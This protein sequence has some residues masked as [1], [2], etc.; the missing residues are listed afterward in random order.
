MARAG[1][2]VALIDDGRTPPETGETLPSA[3]KPI[4]EYLGVREQFGRLG[5]LQSSGTV[6]R[7]GVERVE[8]VGLESP[9][10]HG[11]IVPKG[12]FAKMLR[13]QA[14]RVGATLIHD[15]VA[16]V[17]VGGLF[18]VS[19]A[20]RNVEARVLVDAT[21]RG[22]F[23]ARQL[24]ARHDISDKLLAVVSHMRTASLASGWSGIESTDAGWCYAASLPGGGLALT[25]YT[26]KAHLHIAD[27][28]NE[29]LAG[30]LALTGATV[31]LE[32][33][34]SDR[35]TL[36]GLG[37]DRRTLVAASSTTR[38]T[39]G[40]HWAAV[41]DAACAFDPLASTG[42]LMAL[43]TGVRAASALSADLTG[44]PYPLVEYDAMVSQTVAAYCRRRSQIY[45][46]AAAHHRTDF[47]QRR[48]RI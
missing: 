4:L 37:S 30:I 42:L 31:S 21:G 23:V 9:Y 3:A 26:D 7:W 10:G 16:S 13:D 6:G 11:W 40:P 15:S 46:S 38:P 28:P 34:G 27:P 20:N 22:A 29:L 33:L 36:E 5:S 39:S 17:C 18:S 1:W 35:R 45:A 25:R 43:R 47:W 44:D 8:H 14:A 32:E 24:G 41:G 48:S 19:S 12:A 2:N